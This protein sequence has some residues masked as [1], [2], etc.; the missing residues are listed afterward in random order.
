MFNILLTTQVFFISVAIE[1]PVFE[2]MMKMGLFVGYFRLFWDCGGGPEGPGW[3]IYLAQ[4]WMSWY[5][6]DKFGWC[7]YLWLYDITLNKYDC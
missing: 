2:I 7:G 3:G 1:S 6:E 5:D 4:M